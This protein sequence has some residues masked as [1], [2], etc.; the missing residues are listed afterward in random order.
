M[1]KAPKGVRCD[2]GRRLARHVPLAQRRVARYL[3]SGNLWTGRHR[4]APCRRR[5]GLLAVAVVVRGR[6]AA[7]AVHLHV[8]PQRRG[9]GVGFITTRNSAVVRLVG[10]VDVWVFFPIRGVGEASVAPFVFAFERF[11]AC[12]NKGIFEIFQCDEMEKRFYMHL[13][14]YEW[15]LW[16]RKW[17]ALCIIT[18]CGYSNEKI[19]H[20]VWQDT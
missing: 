13:C 19:L 17:Q 3:W 6:P 9:V 14:K 16:Q 8:L 12:N 20:K 1:S 18:N 10:G 2:W 4:D 7:A 15:L 5:V 11:L